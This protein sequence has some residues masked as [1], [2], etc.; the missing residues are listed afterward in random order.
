[1][2]YRKELDEYIKKSGASSSSIARAIS[3]SPGALSVWMKGSYKGNVGGL[4]KKIHQFLERQKQRVKYG[5]ATMFCHTTNGNRVLQVCKTA[6][7]NHSLCVI[8]SDSG[9]GKT[10]GLKQYALENDVTIYIECD[11]TYSPK[12]LFSII[13]KE[14][15]RPSRGLLEDIY[16]DCIDGL[17]GSDRLLIIDQ[18]ELLSTK[19]LELVRCLHDKTSIGV[20]LAGMPKLIENIRGLKSEFAQMYTRISSHCRLKPLNAEDIEMIVKSYLPEATA[21]MAKVF[22]QHSRQCGRSL[23]LLVQNAIR[24]SQANNIELSPE[25]VRRCAQVMEI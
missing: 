1:M 14:L 9:M 8:T 12:R 19:A 25:L 16:S 11:P 6:H 24:T 10:F 23:G 4:N 15:G 3:I 5:L 13:R 20:V 7:T 21:D 2:D 22:G 18:A 17:Q